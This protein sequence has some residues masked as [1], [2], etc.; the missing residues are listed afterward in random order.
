[1]IYVFISCYRY[2]FHGLD[3]LQELNMEHNG[4]KFIEADALVSLRSLRVAKFSY[5]QL[6]LRTNIIGFF[7]HVSPF[8]E[9]KS[10]EELHLSHNNVS[11]MFA[12][13]TVGHIRLRKL[14]LSYN[15]LDYLQVCV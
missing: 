10:L 9:C 13:W 7:G 4:L 14:D 8:D 1:M 3:A 11:E 15:S 2:L 12:D 5:N 6:N